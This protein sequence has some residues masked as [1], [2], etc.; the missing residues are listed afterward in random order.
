MGW[1]E[2]DAYPARDWYYITWGHTKRWVVLCY[3]N[4]ANHGSAL[5]RFWQLNYWWWCNQTNKDAMKTFLITSNTSCELKWYFIITSSNVDCRQT[6]C[7]CLSI[8]SVSWPHELCDWS[9]SE[10]KHWITQ[11]QLQS[12]MNMSFQEVTTLFHLVLIPLLNW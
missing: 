1:E 3:C 2:G 6:S 8:P 9:L 7:I 12:M 5:I 4:S 11:F 10:M